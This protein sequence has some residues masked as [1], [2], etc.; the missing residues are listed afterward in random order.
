MCSLASVSISSCITSRTDSRI[1]STPS[2]ARNASS[3]SDATDWD[4]AI[5]ENL[6]VSTCR[7]TPRIPPM[8]PLTVAAHRLPEFPL[9]PGTLTHRE[10]PAV[11]DPNSRTPTGCLAVLHMLHA[12][13]QLN[14]HICRDP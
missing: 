2:P 11:L 13:H 9:L 10:L 12:A 5:G 14:A 8:A 4:N 3:S 1:R 7:Y 6:L